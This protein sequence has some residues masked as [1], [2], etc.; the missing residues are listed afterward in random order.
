MKDK[1]YCYNIY[2]YCGNSVVVNSDS[3][4]YAIA[5]PIAAVL[6]VLA[7]IVGALAVVGLVY[8]VVKLLADPNFT[9]LI[10]DTLSNIANNVSNINKAKIQAKIQS[11]A[12]L[13]IAIV[14]I[15]QTLRSRNNCEVHHIVAQ[16][17]SRAANARMILRTVKINVQ[18]S[19][20]KVAIKY[21][22]HRRLHTNIYYDA[23][24]AAIL[25]AYTSAKPHSKKTSVMGVL[26]GIRAMLLY[27]SSLTN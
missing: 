10:S 5:I 20:N 2:N 12:I 14:A 11:I 15:S 9:K 1:I 27:A 3:F 16:S 6:A 17:A 22:L 25:A 13:I 23:V 19:I 8:L 18:D 7:K 24:N 26:L 21:N 4:G